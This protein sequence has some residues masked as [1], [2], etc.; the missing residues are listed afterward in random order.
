M[1]ATQELELEFP[2][3]RYDITMPLLEGR[4]P[5]EGV[6]PK[7]VPSAN[8]MVFRDVPALREG[9]FGLCDLNLG[10]L[11]PAIDAGWEIAALPVFS[12]RKPS[13]QYIFCRADQGIESPKDLEGKRVGT[14]S[15]PTALTIWNQGLLQ[16]RYGVD[17]AKLHWVAAVD[18]FFPIHDDSTQIEYTLDP[19]KSAA[20]VI[21]DGDV[22]AIVTDISDIK[23]L[24]TLVEHPKVRRLFPNYIEE[25]ERLYRETGIFTPVHL[26]VMSA[27]LDREHPG[28]GRRLYDAFE[29]AKQLAHTDILNERGGFAVL[30]L[31]ERLEEQM[32]HW[33]DPWKYGIGANRHTIDTFFRYNLEQGMI[34]SAASY[35]RVFASSTLD[36]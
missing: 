21:I 18:Q 5:I 27:K 30:Y 26:M 24:N 2:I 8:T 16:D 29:Q 28:L 13:Y 19:Q 33:G 17:H 22:D 25:D 11:L 4:I 31:R 23:V 14:R 32:A 1:A 34:R 36:T 12:K 6:K 20:D 3:M 10:Y 15:Y 9:N 35:E 7:P